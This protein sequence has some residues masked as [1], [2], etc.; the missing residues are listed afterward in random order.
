[1]RKKQSVRQKPVPAR[2]IF[3]FQ[4]PT[5]RQDRPVSP[6][7][8]PSMRSPQNKEKYKKRKTKL[9]LP[10]HHRLPSSP[11]WPL[12]CAVDSNWIL[13]RRIKSPNSGTGQS[14]FVAFDLHIHRHNIF[15]TLGVNKWVRPSDIPCSV[16]PRTKKMISTMYG[17]VAVMYTTCQ[18]REI[19]VQLSTGRAESRARSNLAG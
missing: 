14:E 15:G 2:K 18:R 6:T 11:S 16:I 12:C 10:L 4:P 7:G 1:M 9:Y 13:L 19:F 3:V 17:N 5:R 8:S